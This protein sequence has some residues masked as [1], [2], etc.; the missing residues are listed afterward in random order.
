MAALFVKALAVTPA[1]KIGITTATAGRLTF[2]ITHG[3]TT[4]RA[5]KQAAAEVVGAG[6]GTVPPVVVFCREEGTEHLPLCSGAK[7]RVAAIG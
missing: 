7:W 3:S 6:R 5:A 2:G 1:A 4:V